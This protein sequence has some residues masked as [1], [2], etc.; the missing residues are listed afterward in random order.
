M[1]FTDP[2]CNL[3]LFNIV[4]FNLLNYFKNRQI[5]LLGDYNIDVLTASLHQSSSQLYNNIASCLLIPVFTKPTRITPHSQTFDNIFTN[6]P[7]CNCTSKILVDDISDYF[8]IFL[9]VPLKFYPNS[10]NPKQ[11]RLNKQNC[12]NKFISLLNSRD[13]SDVYKYVED[14]NSCLAYSNF[15]SLFS[16]LYNK[17]FPLVSQL[18]SSKKC[19]QPWMTFALLK[20]CKKRINFIDILF[21]IFLNKIRK[22]LSNTELTLRKLNFKPKYYNKLFS[23]YKS[24]MHKTWNLIRSLIGYQ[25][26]SMGISLFFDD[27]GK[28]LSSQD[29]ANKFN[30]YF[31]TI[32]ELIASNIPISSNNSFE[33]YLTQPNIQSM[34]FLPSNLLEIIKLSRTF[35]ISHSCGTDDIDPYIAHEFI[36]LIADPLSSIFNCS[37]CTGLVPLE[38]KSAKVIPIYKSGN[39]SHFS[40]YRPIF[41]LP[42]F[43]KLIEKIVHNRQ[44]DYFDKFN[45]FNK[46]QFGFRKNLSTYMPFLLL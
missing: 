5:F 3:N 4:F 35:K 19:K 41:I 10:P 43:S 45:L 39:Y 36:S 13:W 34:S 23:E 25:N 20:S 18:G 33:S 46:S 8:P 24:N 28:K 14:N 21:N 29:V 37:F 9:Q 44:Y 16:D 30:Q 40:N 26:P 32:G 15:L 31:S 11:F 1:L 12:K 22:L 38:L 2:D 27:N 17:S 42:Y 6:F 7:L